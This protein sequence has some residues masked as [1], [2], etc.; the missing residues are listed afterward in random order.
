MPTVQELFVAGL[1]TSTQR[2]Y[3]S[4]S[5][6]YQKFYCQ[7]DLQPYPVTESVLALF[8]ASLFR[9]GL[10]A[11]TIKT[12]LSSVRYTQISLGLGDPHAKAMPQL[13]YVVKGLKRKTA[14]QTART[15]LPITVQILRDLK[16][17][18]PVAP[19][20]FNASMLWAASCMCFFGFLRTGEIVVPSDTEYDKNVHLSV[21]D[22]LVD[23][24]MSPKWLEIRI[25]ASKTDPFR[26]GV[27]V[28]IGTSGNNICPVAAILD[29]RV[30]R[31][32]CS[33]P[34]FRFSDRR[35][36]TRARFVTQLKEA[37]TTM[38]VDERNYS[39]H[40]SRIGAATTAAACGIQDSLI[41]TL[42]RWESAAYTLYIQTPRETLCKVSQTLT[43]QVPD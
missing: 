41:K 40:S 38:G 32:P 35:L 21:E 33:G 9:Q 27:S 23:N 16:A 34:F 39:G 5:S 30:R 13:E 4:G 29:Y 24:V 10:T 36:L 18:W 1:A 25:K 2:V 6:R 20:Q 3:R 42:G 11:G 37:L 28:Y 12:Y 7:H 43:T 31:G 8:T 19:D 14:G 22:V 15:R 17:V 26:K